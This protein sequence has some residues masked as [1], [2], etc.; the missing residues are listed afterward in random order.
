MFMV[1]TMRV[2]KDKKLRKRIGIDL[3]DILFPFNRHFLIYRNKK[4]N[5][6]YKEEDIFSF[7]YED[8]FNMT[9][10]EVIKELDDF[11]KTK[12]YEKIKPVENSYR[13]LSEIKKTH[14]LVIVTAR[15]EYLF[16][17]TKKWLNKNFKNIFSDVIFTNQSS[18]LDQKRN[19]AEVCV[20]R[21]IE[22]LI[23]DNF[24]YAVDCA[25][26]GIRVLLFNKPWNINKN[27]PEEYAGFIIRINDWNDV[28]IVYESTKRFSDFKK[29]SK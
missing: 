10:E 8:V 20:E 15:P 12:E 5:T 28:L 17:K 29:Y 27:I 2:E 13:V 4:H 14:D 6:N 16:E 19:K 18:L 7:Y 9:T 23:E 11:Y 22:I 1:K 3:D 24:D 21:N 26:N 25:K